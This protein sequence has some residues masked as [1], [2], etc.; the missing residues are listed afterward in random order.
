[1]RAEE[2]LR[3]GTA[4]LEERARTQEKEQELG[5]KSWKFDGRGGS[6]IETASSGTGKGRSDGAMAGV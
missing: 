6:W 2:E 5:K 1:M 3:R 4:K